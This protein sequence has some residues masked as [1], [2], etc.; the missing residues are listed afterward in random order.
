MNSRATERLMNQIKY[1]QDGRTLDEFGEDIKDGY[2]AQSDVL[3]QWMFGHRK[4]QQASQNDGK[5]YELWFFPIGPKCE[6]IDDPITDDGDVRLALG[7]IINPNKR[8][9]LVVEIKTRQGKGDFFTPKKD[10]VF[11]CIENAR[12]YFMVQNYLQDDQYLVLL[13]KEDLIDIRDNY[14]SSPQKIYNGKE[15]YRIEDFHNFLYVT[16]PKL[17]PKPVYAE[18]CQYLLS[19][20]CS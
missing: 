3:Y 15:G 9:D 1:R 4:M 6:R 11:R 14:I 7:H 16:F 2:L 18:M 17:H 10:D 12:P 5:N 20:K 19:R 13:R 8:V